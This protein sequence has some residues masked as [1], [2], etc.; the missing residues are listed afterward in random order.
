MAKNVCELTVITDG[1]EDSFRQGLKFLR[2]NQIDEAYESFALAYT[3]KDDDARYISYY[4]LILALKGGDLGEALTVCTQALRKDPK[5]PEFYLNMGRVYLSQGNKA[6]A[7]NSFRKGL[8]LNTGHEELL[9]FINSVGT[10]GR[11]VLPV[12]FQYSCVQGA[13][14]L[15]KGAA[16][17]LIIRAWRPALSGKT[18]SQACL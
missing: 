3:S 10:R 6:G 9:C 18:S 2:L 7:I 5:N 15:K 11:A 12:A 17:N 16:M 14:R 13:Y 1:P 4:G 8:Q